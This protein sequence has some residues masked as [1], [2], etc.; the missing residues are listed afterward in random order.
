MKILIVSGGNIDQDFASGFLK[1]Q[2]YDRI[3]AVD[4]GAQFCHEQGLQ[5]TMLIGDFDSLLPEIL[6]VYEE[7][8]ITVRRFRPEKDAADI[9]IAL[10]EAKEMLRES[11]ERQNCVFE[12]KKDRSSLVTILG[13]TGTRLDH[14][15]GTLY[16][17]AGLG[18]EVPCQLVDAN[19]RVRMLWP[20][21]YP[22]SRS[23]CFGP[24]LSLIPIGGPAEHITIRGFKY[25]L[26]DHRMTCDHSLG[27]SN[28]LVSEIGVISF[29]R[30]LLACFETRDG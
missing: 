10:Q 11:N 26:T 8:G 16:S 23:E 18:P 14:M 7:T 25:P 15:M 6:D 27:V 4:K 1:D 9:E 3:L 5:P 28:E 24:Y 17:M 13:G 12:E 30:G 21:T 2:Y 29:R 22:V 19:N 20:G